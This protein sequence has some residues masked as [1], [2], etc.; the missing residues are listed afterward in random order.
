MVFFNFNVFVLGLFVNGIVAV[1]IPTPITLGKVEA[2]N[3]R[4]TCQV[5][6]D[7]HFYQQFNLEKITDSLRQ[8]IRKDINKQA[9]GLNEYME[10]EKG[11]YIE[12]EVI[13]YWTLVK[14]YHKKV[15]C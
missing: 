2:P 15:A 4:R 13:E 14:Y 10:V 3:E 12:Y 6:K 9:C 5:L 7:C 11:I 1:P 8:A